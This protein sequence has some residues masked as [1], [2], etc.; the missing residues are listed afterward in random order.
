VKR[1]DCMTLSQASTI[2]RDF[3][4]FEIDGPEAE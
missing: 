2:L 4:L 1:I 3:P